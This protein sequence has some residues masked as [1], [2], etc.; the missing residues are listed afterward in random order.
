M[1]RIFGIYTIGLIALWVGLSFS[2]GQH[3]M[4]SSETDPMQIDL[5]T[6]TITQQ[7]VY[8]GVNSNLT[9]TRNYV[10]NATLDLEVDM[11]LGALLVDTVRIAP[12]FVKIDGS[13]QRDELILIPSGSHEVQVNFAWN[14]Y[15]FGPKMVE[16]I[17]PAPSGMALEKGQAKLEVWIGAEKK[18][19][20][21]G[22]IK[23]L[24]SIYAP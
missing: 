9:K 17:N 2:C 6:A 1:K 16:E 24:E 21:L 22:E 13:N 7:D 20:D 18:L 8:P 23:I 19:L 4:Q 14:F 3:E 12:G 11:R 15:G 5:S 10:L